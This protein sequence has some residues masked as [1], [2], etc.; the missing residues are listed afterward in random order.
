MRDCRSEPDDARRW[1]YVVKLRVAGVC[2]Y[3]MNNRSVRSCVALVFF[4]S[5]VVVDD[6]HEQDRDLL[7]RKD[8]Q[9]CNLW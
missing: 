9:P 8:W 6:D 1:L 4:E 7:P 2:R 3:L 5:V